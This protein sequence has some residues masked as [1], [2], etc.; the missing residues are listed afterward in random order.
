MSLFG[1][2]VTYATKSNALPGGSSWL[3]GAGANETFTVE[4][5]AA[6][7]YCLAV[8]K[9]G[10]A[11]L[12][13]AGTYTLTVF[14][15]VSAVG[16]EN[17][18]PSL[19]RLASV[20]P[21]PFNPATNLSFDLARSET[22]VLAVYD[23]QGRRVRALLNETRSAGRHTVRWDGLDDGGR[24]VGSAVYIARFQAGAVSE[25]RKLVLLK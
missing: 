12:N 19:T 14:S 24:A 16:D 10:S 2:N 7:Y 6:G 21:N 9:V 3:A 20:Q 13:V 8:W 22:V 1:E 17:A 23:L 5:P 15:G 25:N 18:A 4:V 11:D